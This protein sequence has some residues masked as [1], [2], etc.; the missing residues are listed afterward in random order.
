MFRKLLPYLLTILLWGCEKQNS[1]KKPCQKE[2]KVAF[3]ADVHFSDVYP[4]LEESN[5]K[6]IYD[7]VENRSVLVRTMNAQLHSTRLFNENYFAFFAALNDAIARGIKIIVLPGDFSDDGQLLHVKGLRKILDRYANDYNISFFLINGNHDPTTPFGE[8][9]GKKDFLGVNGK[10]Q[11][12]LSNEGRYRAKSEFENTTQVVVDLKELGYAE[13]VKELKNHGFF[14]KKHFR[15][16]STPF[17]DFAYEDYS[18]DT[19]QKASDLE[20]RTYNL[21]IADVALPDVSYLVEPVKGLWLLALD[22][23]VF[24]P[25]ENGG[26]RGTGIGY[27][28]V[29]K[30]KK[31]L[32]RWTEQVVKDAERLGKTLIAFSHYPMV[33]FNDGASKEMEELFGEKSFQAHRIPKVVVGQTFADIGLKLHIGGHMH[34]NDTGI[35]KTFKGNTLINI[36]TPSLAA[37]KP[38]YKIITVT[39]NESLVVETIVLDSVPE[40]DTFFELYRKEHAFLKRN[41]K[42]KMWDEKILSSET[43]KEFTNIHLKELVRWRFLAN[44]WPVPLKEILVG[45]T[46]WQLLQYVN[47]MKNR[48]EEL[49]SSVLTETE[50]L[51]KISTAGLSKSDFI[52]FKGEDLIL[53]FYRLRSAD[54]LALVDISSNQLKA[55]VFLFDILAQKKENEILIP[56]QQ[57][58]SIFRKQMN[59]EEATNF[60]VNLHE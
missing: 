28:E 51:K 13:M 34:L 52:N 46:G 26:F 59:G 16:W 60:K 11:P 49:K 48:K 45:R 35:L 10:A 3:M 56:L 37:Y 33:D 19:A 7:S 4:N 15:F 20:N 9:G 1:P 41:F 40:F 44:D 55:Y 25:T 47:N 12:I 36:Q 17:S 53:D 8:E 18:F 57:F 30:Y 22:A 58:A 27:N 29:L 2:I 24:L 6:G 5:Y 21:D 39:N 38:G 23:N 14:P 50:L 43:Y 32:V 42:D 31:Y 54:K